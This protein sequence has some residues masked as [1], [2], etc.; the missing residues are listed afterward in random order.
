MSR[1]EVRDEGSVTAETAVVMPGLVLV[2]AVCLWAVG[3]V[4]AQLR[5]VEAARAGARAAARGETDADV[6][7]RARHAA[8]DGADVA[9]ERRGDDVVVRIRLRRTA[10]GVLGGL[11]PA[12]VV[13]ADATAQREPGQPS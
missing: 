3:L 4:G 13:S 11:L 7:A 10:P 1:I 6:A 5:C 12:Y 9:V 2:L 8:G